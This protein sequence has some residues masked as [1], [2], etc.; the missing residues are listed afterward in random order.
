[1][2]AL[3]IIV[4]TKYISMEK[5]NL[6]QE[7]YATVCLKKR[8]SNGV[9]KCHKSSIRQLKSQMSFLPQYYIVLFSVGI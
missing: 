9:V 7:T 3:S 8:H 1:M 4:F 2:F 6:G 5:N